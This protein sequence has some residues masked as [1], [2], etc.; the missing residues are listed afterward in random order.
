MAA[1]ASRERR[2]TAGKR[3]TSLVGKAQDEDDTF[4]GHDT[5][6]EDDSGN[7]SF[8]DSDEDSAMKKDHFDSDFDDSESDH[9]EEERAAGA[10]EEANLQKSERGAMQRKNTYVDIKKASSG[11]VAA[12]RKGVKGHKRIMGAGINAG[13]VLNAP[14][15]AMLVASV[16]APPTDPL[17]AQQSLPP[18]LVTSL[19]PKKFVRTAAG[20]HVKTTLASTRER[21]S[22]HAPRRLR[23]VRSTA[24]ADLKR[25]SVGKSA[26]C[27][28][29]ATSSK[30]TKRRRY[31][32]EELLLEA[33]NETEPENSRWLLAR[34]RVQENSEK[35]KDLMSMRNAS[36]G[37]VVQ[38]YHSRRGCLITLTFP[39]MDSVPEILTRPNVVVTKP[40][41]TYCVI[42]GE[43]ARY[44]DPLTNLGYF[45]MAAF[46]ELRRRH[47]GGEAL[48]K[49]TV[50]KE[51]ENRISTASEDISGVTEDDKMDITD[52]EI[53]K[54]AARST[55]TSEK[56]TDESSFKAK[57]VTNDESIV[58]AV[59]PPPIV[60]ASKQPSANATKPKSN[61]SSHSDN[62]SNSKGIQ[63]ENTP[64]SSATQNATIQLE[65]PP[66]SPTRRASRRKWKPSLKLLDNIVTGDKA[67]EAVSGAHTV[68]KEREGNVESIQ[69]T[70]NSTL[71]EAVLTTTENTE[72]APK[73]VKKKATP[74]VVADKEVDKPSTNGKVTSAA[75]KTKKSFK[76]EP[77][78][79]PDVTKASGW[80]ATSG[81]KKPSKKQQA[82]VVSANGT[83]DAVTADKTK[84]ETEKTASLEQKMPAA[85]SQPVDVASKPEPIYTVPP[86]N[87]QGEEPRF[88]TQSELIMAAITTYNKLQEGRKHS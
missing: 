64:T 74:K 18:T 32:Q 36:R 5:W 86:E 49:R 6:A 84:T 85:S 68:R 52:S 4:W 47:R 62:I 28:K 41:P 70:E 82:A 12:K 59:T 55:K 23:E 87:S 73:T 37:K 21:R 88:V 72:E 60:S 51:D 71:E 50:K 27:G 34:K 7:D 20:A 24:P 43:R 58:S 44:R 38:K 65:S 25:S 83:S 75:P 16:Q 30:K 15:A 2:K 77:E 33:V 8:H 67:V 17:L 61:G 66:V 56:K 11:L 63:I 35:D 31:G 29:S 76:K 39:E 80:A 69:E 14:V 48:D 46:N 78:S 3:M 40:N 13:I 1:V 45:D 42:T 19:P 81:A 79:P 10:D 9:D 53:A 57:T 22:A 54:D 26:T